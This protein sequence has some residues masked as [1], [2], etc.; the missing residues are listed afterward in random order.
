MRTKRLLLFSLL[1]SQMKKMMMTLII[2]LSL[3][4]AVGQIY[5]SRDMTEFFISYVETY[6]SLSPPPTTLS[7]SLCVC[8]CACACVC[9]IHPLT[10]T[11]THTYAL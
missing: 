1:S 11:H 5:L 7:I 4:T 3:W 2:A 8:A 6:W 9:E 10:H